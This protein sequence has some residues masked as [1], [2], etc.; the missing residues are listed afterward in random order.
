MRFGGQAN[1]AKL[2]RPI[3]LLWGARQFGRPYQQVVGQFFS[4]PFVE[5][6]FGS[7]QSI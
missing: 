1:G 7:K 6:F 2:I 4:F 3:A 5:Y